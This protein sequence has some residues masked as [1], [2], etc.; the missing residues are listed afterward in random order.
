MSGLTFIVIGIAA[1][2]VLIGILAILA[3]RK[4]RE[5]KLREINYRTFLI[6]GLTFLSLGIIYEIVFFVSDTKVALVLGLAFIAMGISYLAIGLG[7][8]DKW[9]K[10]VDS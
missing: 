6:L 4:K 2:L 7:N 5:E 3:S 10:N 9:K 1:G 8:R